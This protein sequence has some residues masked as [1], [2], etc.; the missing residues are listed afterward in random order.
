MDMTWLFLLLVVFAV[1]VVIGIGVV[2][3]IVFLVARRPKK[4]NPSMPTLL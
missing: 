4:P 3:L 1:L 2:L